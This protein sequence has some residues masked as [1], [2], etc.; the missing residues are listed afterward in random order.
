MSVLDIVSESVVTL[1]DGRVASWNLAATTLYGWQ[2][3]EAMERDYQAFL[4]EYPQEVL[5]AIKSQGSWEG[6]L[7]RRRF[8][9]SDIQ[10]RV[11][12]TGSEAL[13]LEP[14]AIV[15]VS[16]L[17]D[18]LHPA[19]ILLAASEYRYRNLFGAVAAAFW[20]MDFS[21]VGAILRS[22]GEP[23]RE[24]LGPYLQAN[25]GLVR[26]MM[27]STRALDANERA[28]ELFGTG[29]KRE[30]LAAPGDS[31]WPDSSTADYAASVV[32]AVSG[33]PRFIAE[34]RVR[35]LS[36]REFEALFTVSFL[37]NT[38]GQGSL[39]VGFTDISERVRVS[40]E[41]DQVALRQKMFLEIP[42]IAMSEMDTTELIERFD[43]LRDAGVEDLDAYIGQ[44]PEFLDFALSAVRFAE[45]NEA[46]V[47]MFGAASRQELIGLPLTGIF[48]PARDVFRQS[49]VGNFNGEQIFQSELRMRR[50]D[51]REVTTIF[52]R[53][54]STQYDRHRVL[55]AQIDVTEQVQAREELE[56]LQGQLAHASRISLLGELSASIAHEISQPITAI[57]TGAVA[58]ERIAKRPDFNGEWLSTITQR[59]LRDA[60]R[61]GEIIDRI[62]AMASNQSVQLV[63]LMV[64][65]V[66]HGAHQ[67]VARELRDRSVAVRFAI[68]EALPGISGD[69]VQLQQVMVNLIMNA[70][71]A[72]DM[73]SREARKIDIEAV[74]ADGFVRIRILDTGPGFPEEEREAAFLSFHSSKAN[75]LGLGLSI[76]R[77]I[78]EG[79]N[80][81]IRAGNREGRTGAEIVIELPIGIASAGTAVCE[82]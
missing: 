35:S 43:E 37:P 38:V 3:Q 78:V 50:L 10:V 64:A 48:E 59:I 57:A 80:G 11:R 45:V 14:G 5:A 8:D 25:P 34:T 23:Q 17:V 1:R 60:T 20:E 74:S 44:H 21:G 2:P 69:R 79:H 9:G 36:G 22:L 66:I 16:S 71:Q 63:P 24:N 53:L 13:G 82:P 19:E 28:L 18:D 54:V 29:T 47:R 77:S 4:G 31:F 7:F 52:C 41:L 39:L 51:G 65:E 55:A 62:R 26:E 70:A 81:T 12:C 15:E 58:A 30:L 42:A 68:E 61:A 72:M 76:C 49:I 32:A 46:S 27:R 56:R 33:Q 75:G 67:L 6:R 73:T 40:R